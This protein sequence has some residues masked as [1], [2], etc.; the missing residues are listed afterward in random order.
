MAVEYAFNERAHLVDSWPNSSRIEPSADQEQ[1]GALPTTPSGQRHSSDVPR[2]RN[3]NG[4]R[5][6]E[7][8][9]RPAS[10]GER[11]TETE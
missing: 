6:Q 5:A 1:D 4:R 10:L 9:T 2:A 8:E 7:A 3:A 11:H